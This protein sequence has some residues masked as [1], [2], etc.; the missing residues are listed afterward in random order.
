[1]LHQQHHH[2]LAPLQHRQVERRVAL[3][4]SGVDL[5]PVLDEL[6]RGLLEV[7]VRVRA[8]A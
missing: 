7:K 1:V 6:Q 5:G 8:R 3:G 4:V 2:L